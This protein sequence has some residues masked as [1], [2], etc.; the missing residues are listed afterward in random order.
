MLAAIG[1]TGGTQ[2]LRAARAIAG[3]EH[4][5]L[6][7]ASVVEPP[8]IYSFETSHPVLLPWL[9]DQQLGERRE[10]VHDRLRELGF[11]TSQ[12]EHPR[13]EV[14]YGD[15]APSIAEVARE[16]DA[17][18]IVLGIG[19]HSLRHRLLSSGTAWA[20][21]RRASCPTL[22]VADQSRELPRVVVVATDFSP[23]SIH[24]ARSA[25]PLLADDAV[26]HLVHAWSRADAAF[27]SAAL[28][29]LN[30][31]Y[32]AALPERFVRLRRA[33]GPL[34]GIAVEEHVLEGQPAD[35][36]LSLARATQADL[37]VAGTHG[38]GAVQRWL[39]GSTSSA[40]LRGAD[41]SVLLA[42]QP[43]AAERL[44]LERLVS[45]ADAPP[46]VGV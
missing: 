23:E 35:L 40:L 7:V 20:T 12:R 13:V 45:F 6:V 11:G 37:I 26:V 36:V 3:R 1:A 8:P 38:R 43:P 22:A 32:V 30:E 34:G 31:R 9:V 46:V 15:S 16:L 39:L 29:T 14:R 5:E 33:L 4:A 18:L 17:R 19:P 10:S 21:G 2:P 28:A 25:L 44:E 42:P 27:P 24:A 41:C